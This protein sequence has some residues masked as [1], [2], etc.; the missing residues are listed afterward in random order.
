[1]RFV[2]ILLLAIFVI[3]AALMILNARARRRLEQLGGDKGDPTGRFPWMR[4]GG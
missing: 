2:W 3:V 4:S 1:M